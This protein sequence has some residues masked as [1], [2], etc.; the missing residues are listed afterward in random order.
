M[1]PACRCHWIADW[2]TAMTT[3]RTESWQQDHWGYVMGMQPSMS[4]FLMTCHHP[5]W[6]RI[7]P[8]I[9]RGTPATDVRVASF[10]Q[11]I[12]K[13]PQGTM[14]EPNWPGRSTRACLTKNWGVARRAYP[15]PIYQTVINSCWSLG[16]LIFIL[17]LYFYVKIINCIVSWVW[18]MKMNTLG[19]IMFRKDI[20]FKM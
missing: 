2:M 6:C 20:L 1:S 11:L 10:P 18:C 12:C 4:G 13:E 7:L 5:P 15:F 19:H 16:F 14:T 17:F 8:L 3:H 9:Q